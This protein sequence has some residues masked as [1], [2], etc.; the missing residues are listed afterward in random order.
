[1][2]LNELCKLL[3]SAS[4]LSGY[5]NNELT[6][7]ITS[8]V[9]CNLTL[10]IES[11]TDYPTQKYVLYMTEPY[12]EGESLAGMYF[13]LM[14]D[15]VEPLGDYVSHFKEFA[16]SEEATVSNLFK[17]FLREGLLYED[18]LHQPFD[19]IALTEG[20][21]DMP[22]T[23]TEEESAV[24][25]ES[26]KVYQTSKDN[27]LVLFRGS[28]ACYTAHTDGNMVSMRINSEDPDHYSDVLLEGGGSKTHWGDHGVSKYLPPNVA[29][30]LYNLGGEVVVN[31]VS[32]TET[33]TCTI[34]QLENMACRLYVREKVRRWDNT[35]RMYLKKAFS[36]MYDAVAEGD[37]DSVTI[38]HVS[39]LHSPLACEHPNASIIQFFISDVCFNGHRYLCALYIEHPTE[40]VLS[41][42]QKI[43]RHQIAT[44]LRHT[45]P[46]DRKYFQLNK[47]RHGSSESGWGLVGGKVLESIDEGDLFWTPYACLSYELFDKTVTK[48]GIAIIPNWVK[49]QAR[50]QEENE[51]Y[52]IVKQ[53]SVSC[54]TFREH[55][56]DGDLISSDLIAP[57]A[58]SE[59]LKIT[60]VQLD[61]C[62]Y[63]R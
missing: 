26:L 51:K 11:G 3:T 56:V 57:I 63:R 45:P 2:T 10:R 24:W 23:L 43:R 28:N 32:G 39:D 40:R 30:F 61:Y 31:A 29:K 1:M 35:R 60:P 54:F 33:N 6:F 34:F 16:E 20:V 42:D 44:L 47:Y 4:T 14:K 25:L 17:T 36:D 18:N 50:N 13:T 55:N 21:R 15:E 5:K 38:R 7:L 9:E 8:E 41:S 46:Y 58:M 52:S 12:P 27:A 37:E 19:W 62:N 59:D 22:T 48:N 53:A 49:I